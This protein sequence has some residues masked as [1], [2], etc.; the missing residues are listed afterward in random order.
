MHRIQFREDLGG[1][2]L[3]ELH[4]PLLGRQ[5]SFRNIRQFTAWDANVIP[6][7]VSKKK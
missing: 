7:H 4:A 2:L 6:Q 3:A 5:R 1:K